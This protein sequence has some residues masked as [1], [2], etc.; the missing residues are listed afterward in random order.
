MITG[1]R[2][3]RDDGAECNRKKLSA[4]ADSEAGLHP[5]QQPHLTLR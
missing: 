2:K 3:L 4:A 5:P 1:V